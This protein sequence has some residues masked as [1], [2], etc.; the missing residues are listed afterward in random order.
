MTT[1]FVGQFMKLFTENLKIMIP[2]KNPAETGAWKKL[3]AYY[4]EFKGK[5]IK[6]LFEMDSD[7][8]ENY[9][10]SFEDI[11]VDF[12]KNRIDETV[13]NLLNELASECGLKEAISSMFA[14]QKINATENRAVLHVALRNRSN[15]PI[16]VDGDDVMPEVNAVLDQMKDFSG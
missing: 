8:F 14:G 3:E 5:Q 11:L 13:L 6:E 15:K 10:L 7:R 9:S 16:L 4:A 1:P 2:K 12:S